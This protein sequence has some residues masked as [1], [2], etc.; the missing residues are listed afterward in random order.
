MVKKVYVGLTLDILHNGHTR[1]LEKAAALG[2][3]TVGLLTNS[4]IAGHKRIPLL[5]WE[6]RA[7]IARSLNSV[8]EVVEQTE[9]DYSLNILKY[10][11][12]YFVH[13][14]DWLTSSS[15]LRKNAISA[16]SQYGGELIEVP[17]TPL[18]ES[19]KLTSQQ[20]LVLS[21]PDR[22]RATL[23]ENLKNKKILRFIEAHSPLS[24]LISEHLIIKN[25]DDARQFDGFWSSSLT[26]STEMGMP[27]IEAL[28]ISKRLSNISNIFDV[29]SK[30][31]I[32]DGDTGGIVEHLKLN[33][34]SME[35]LG[36]SALIIEDKTGLKKNSLFGNDVEQT[37]ADPHE[38]ARKI[39]GAK[40]AITSPDFM[41]IARIES[42]ILDKSVEDALA[43]AKIYT[44]AGADGIMI[45]S[46]KKSTDELFEFSHEFRKS[47]PDVPLVAVPSS[48]SHVYETDLEAAGFNI[49]IYANHLLRA[50][51]RAM[52]EVASS[53]L[54]NQRAHEV[55]DDII[56]IKEILKLIPGTE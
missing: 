41:L 5:N 1:L 55:E 26:D 29:T 17:S 45:H 24:A 48:Y 56:S 54:E 32:M 52:Q 49:V 4:A 38:F 22:R 46:R 13:G 28:D 39:Q 35:R 34:N 2:T 47:Y 3:V 53:I 30:P 33:I 15:N 43:R 36:I 6:Q 51:Y 27:D 42:L 37:Q 50:S 12:D 23:R 31:M 40:T 19:S 9:W 25:G 18:I 14:D 20:H 11:P 7:E 44:E 10:K 21:R 8:T 16:L